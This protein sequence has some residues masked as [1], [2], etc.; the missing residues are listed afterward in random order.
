MQLFNS[1]RNYGAIPQA[2][3]W[4]TVVLV[5]VAWALGVFGDVLPKGAPRESGLFVH[6]TAGIVILA[7]LVVRLVWRLADPSPPSEVTE[8]ATWMGKW[9]D[10]AA[11]VAH[12]VLY[13]LLFAVPVV[14]IVLQFA[15]G[16]A[17]LLFGISEIASPWTKD[18]VFAHNVKEVHEL[19]AHALVVLAALHAAAALIHHWIF[20]DRTLMRMLPHSDN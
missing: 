18:R 3:H 11:R 1:A 4:L 14:G 7:L 6:A 10:P 17:L 20:R 5:A 8:F 2:L 13:A 12:Y 16:D 9:Q 19:L 15:R